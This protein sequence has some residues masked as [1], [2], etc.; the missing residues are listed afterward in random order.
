MSNVGLPFRAQLVPMLE[1]HGLQIVT[2]GT[3]G[4]LSCKADWTGV[5]ILQA[6]ASLWYRGNLVAKGDGANCGW[7]TWVARDMAVQGIIGR[8]VGALDQ[9]LRKI[10]GSQPDTPPVV[11]SY[12]LGKQS[13]R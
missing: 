8:A 5:A 1:S 13:E 6:E 7:G 11:A 9:E 2:N 10:E 4:A 3:P 12:P